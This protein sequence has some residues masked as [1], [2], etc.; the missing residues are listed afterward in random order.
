MYVRWY[1][2]R[3]MYQFHFLLPHSLSLSLLPLPFLFVAVGGRRRRSW[4][5]IRE[6]GRGGRLEEERKHSQEAAI[7]RRSE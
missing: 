6:A 1:I 5:I 3:S 7:K 4:K 2:V